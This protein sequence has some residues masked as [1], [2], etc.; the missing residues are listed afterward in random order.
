MGFAQAVRIGLNNFFNPTGRASRSE[1]WW[2]YLFIFVIAGVLGVIGGMVS[3]HGGEEQT[4]VGIIFDVLAFLI[5]LSV[6]FASIRRLHDIG[7]SGWNLLWN[8][9]PFFGGI[10]LLILFCKPSQPCDNEYG[11]ERY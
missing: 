9:I 10:Y 5:G 3:A 4:W 8:L 1:F 7:K 6:F 11:P 2:Y